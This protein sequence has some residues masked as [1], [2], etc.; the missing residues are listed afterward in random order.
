MHRMYQGGFHMD[1]QYEVFL[2]SKP[3]GKV[4]LIRQGLYCRVICRC[5]LPNDGVYRLYVQRDSGREN[6]GVVIPEG[7]GSFLDKRIPAKRIGEGKL[8]FVLSSGAASVSGTFYPISPEEPF[9]YID[10]LKNA[11]LESENGKVGIRIKE[12]PE[13]V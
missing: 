12:H 8:H 1:E 9:L 13:A 5:L 4:Q 2:S 6:L 11:F 3:V 7:D 10:R